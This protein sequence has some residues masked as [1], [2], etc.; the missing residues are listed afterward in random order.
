MIVLEER[1]RGKKKNLDGCD[2]PDLLETDQGTAGD[3]LVLRRERMQRSESDHQG[4]NRTTGRKETPITDVA[5]KALG[6]KNDTP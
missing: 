5:S 6:R 3:E 1:E 4:R 2:N